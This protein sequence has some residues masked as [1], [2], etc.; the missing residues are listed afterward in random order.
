[1]ARFHDYNNGLVS[2]TR[3]LSDLLLCAS[4]LGDLEPP[5]LGT[6]CVKM[7][8]FQGT[9][10]VFC[11]VTLKINHTYIVPGCRYLTD[12]GVT[13]LKLHI[14][15][16][17]HIKCLVNASEP[18]D[19]ARP[20]SPTIPGFLALPRL[21][22]HHRNRYPA[23]PGQSKP[24]KATDGKAKKVAAPRDGYGAVTRA[25]ALGSHSPTDEER[26]W[27]NKFREQNRLRKEQAEAQ[28]MIDLLKKDA[29]TKQKEVDLV[30]FGK[31]AKM[32]ISHK[33]RS[34]PKG[35]MMRVGASLKVFFS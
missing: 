22:N 16:N 26:A 4:V 28:A 14:A 10:K 35:L 23:L 32:G 31:V 34:L 30:L 17:H 6:Y 9:D 2:P 8:L 18:L 21:R 12:A 25:T 19:L 5:V 33:A 24:A 29:L 1:M 3:P 20:D 27:S 7:F 11:Q 15:M 13:L